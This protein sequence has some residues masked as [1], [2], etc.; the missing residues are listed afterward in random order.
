MS[1]LYF[2]VRGMRRAA[3]ADAASGARED[4]KKKKTE[5]RSEM[6]TAMIG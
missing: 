1:G 4:K 3:G 5:N 2:Y 6:H